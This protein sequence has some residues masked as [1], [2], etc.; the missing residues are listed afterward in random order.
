MDVILEFFKSIDWSTISA[1]VVIIG[2]I[3]WAVIKH[4]S[5]PFVK[6]LGEETAK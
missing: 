3:I 4:F 2:L 6:S 5:K 1:N